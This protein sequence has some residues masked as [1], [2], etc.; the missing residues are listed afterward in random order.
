MTGSP[1]EALPFSYEEFSEW[2]DDYEGRFLHPALTTAITALDQYLDEELQDPQRVRVRITPGRVKSRQRAWQKLNDKYGDKVGS[3]ADVPKVVDDLVGLR[4][5]CTNK[6]DMG[7]VVEMLE[8]LDEYSDGEHPVLAV[9]PESV[10]D[11]RSSPKESG[12][13]AY[14]VN[15][16]TSVSQ[17]TKRHPVICE[18]Q[19]RTLLQDSWGE[20]THEDT[21]KPGAT[22]VPP[23][24]DTLS[25][26]MADLMA[27]ID[28][29]AE[30]L[31]SE[32]DS[33]EADSLGANGKTTDDREPPAKQ[34]ASSNPTREAAEAYLAELTVALKRPTPL[35]TLAWEL[36]RE[37]GSDLSKDWAGHGTFRAMLESAVPQARVSGG[38]PVWVLPADFDVSAY[39]G[40]HPDFPRVVSLLKDADPSFPL[41][42]SELWPRVYAVLAEATQA[43]VWES[44][45][46]PLS[47]LMKHARDA[48]MDNFGFALSRRQLNYVANALL[49]KK[50]LTPGMT[51]EQIEEA[52]VAW[53]LKRSSDIGISRDD[54]DQIAAWLRGQ[55][56]E[57]SQVPESK[58]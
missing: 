32:I 7:R 52:F 11:W 54:A 23:L 20:L 43:G 9:V 42:P 6:S 53:M 21:Y 13:R 12:Y 24:M 29:I 14:H 15:L 44:E 28:D 45:Q 46:E 58:S 50:Q 27:S 18:L 19:V 10:N 56:P 51:A 4:I 8:A 39:D 5:V 37:F 48:S 38:P 30:D 47:K 26:R 55:G 35:A 49:S 41:I 31:R 25:R 40:G 34:K 16:C 2:F 33:Q 1:G 17:V 3:L 22:D 57:A 36:Q